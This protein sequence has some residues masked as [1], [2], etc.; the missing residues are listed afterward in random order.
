MDWQLVIN[1][2]LAGLIAL[3][4]WLARELW[5][6][7]KGLQEEVKSIQIHMP[8]NYV[9][10]D[11]FAEHMHRIEQKLDRIYERLEGKADR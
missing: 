11:E 2:A 8:T 10:R 4:G 1:W 3:V 5:G 7:V 9:R 6:A